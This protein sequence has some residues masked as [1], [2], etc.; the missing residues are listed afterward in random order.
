[1]IYQYKAEHFLPIEIDQAWT[2][3][4]SAKNLARITPPEMD[5]QIKTELDDREIYEGML[6]DYTVKPLLGIPLGWQTEIF[7]VN[8][9]YVFS[10][11]QRKGPYVMWEHTHTF[12][13]T[14]SG[15]LMTDQV[16]YQ[17]PFG[18]LGDF[19]HALFIKKKIERIFAYRKDAL[20]RIF[21]SV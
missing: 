1:M 15:V 5:F 19:A 8:K 17:L 20:N 11:R 10:D 16:N 12:S 3:F 21:V 18:L 6:I 9:P 2:F 7:N 13:E 4:S 14:E